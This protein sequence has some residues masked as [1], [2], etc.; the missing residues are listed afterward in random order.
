MLGS[1][2]ASKNS[3]KEEVDYVLWGV[4]NHGGGPSRK[5]LEDIKNLRVDGVKF[6]HSSPEKLFEDDIRVGGEVR[7]SLVPCMPGCYS[8]MS[9]LK[10]LHRKTEN[11]FYATE[12]MLAL[13]EMAGL[14]VD[15][16]QLKIA[17]KKNL[18]SEVHDICPV[19]S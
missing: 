16:T 14:K 18:L 2:E 17:E 19:R 10:T 6:L 15:L 3:A 8:S 11:L 12:K 9:R 5:D 4:G 7:T 13:A 1:G